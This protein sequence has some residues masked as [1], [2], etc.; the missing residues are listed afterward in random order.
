[1]SSDLFHVIADPTRRRLLEELGGGERSVG[2]LVD[3]LGVSQ[4]TVSKHLRV[5]REAG[6]VFIRAQGQRRFYA[7]DPEPFAPVLAWMRALGGEESLPDAAGQGA[8]TDVAVPEGREGDVLPAEGDPAD[9]RHGVGRTMEQVTGRAQEFL[10]R[11]SKP[12]F[13]RRR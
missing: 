4:P 9:R 10:D 11:L 8:A 13:G 5:L 7:L 12:R 3:A 1:M 2:D 6:V